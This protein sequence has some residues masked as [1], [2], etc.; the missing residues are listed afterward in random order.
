VSTN[1]VDLDATPP[2]VMVERIV[3]EAAAHG[4]GVGEG[5][6]VGLL[7]ARCVTAAA[8]AEGIE[9]PLDDRGVPG[10]EA[11]DVAARAL[12]LQGLDVDRVVEWHLVE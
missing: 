6:L 11:L 7:P 4:A 8:Q 9:N 3:E 1:V 10:Q 2:H 5:E 12:R